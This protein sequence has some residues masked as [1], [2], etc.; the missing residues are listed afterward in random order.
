MNREDRITSYIE[1]LGTEMPAYLTEIAESAVS[2]DIP[3][4]R[5]A[6]RD[7]MRTLLIIHKPMS[8]LEIGTAVGFSALYMREY[9]PDACRITTIENYEPRIREA[10]ENLA[11]FDTDGRITLIEGDAAALIADMQVCYDFIFVDGPKGQY[12]NMYDD[13]KRLL[14]PG[15]ILL[16]DNVF[17]DGDVLESRYAVMRRDRTIHTRMRE[18]LYELTHDEDYSTSILPVADGVALSVRK[19][20]PLKD[21]DMKKDNADDITDKR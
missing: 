14:R 7:L 16:S 11:R 13:M 5:P 12:V 4:I 19:T 10:K 2:R 20:D 18:Y 1:S 9:A 3:I 17:M 8:I 21:P 6:M 15:G